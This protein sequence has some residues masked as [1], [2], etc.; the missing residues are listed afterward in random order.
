MQPGKGFCAV[1][2][3][4]VSRTEACGLMVEEEGQQQGGGSNRHRTEAH[5]MRRPGH[6]GGSGQLGKFAL[7]KEVMGKETD[8]QITG[9][10][11]TSHL[12]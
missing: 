7:W 6:E 11:L 8:V 10:G 5:L 12:C 4:E 1:A 2:W 3:A 9:P